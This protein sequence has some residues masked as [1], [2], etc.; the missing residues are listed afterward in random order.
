MYLR[1]FTRQADLVLPDWSKRLQNYY[2][3]LRVDGRNKTLRRRY[4]RAVELEKLRLAELG[5]CQLQ[6]IGVCRYL[7]GFNKGSE[8]RLKQLFD[9]NHKQLHLPFF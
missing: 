5:L 7:S 8:Q 3:V 2:V 9:N 1:G 4:Y 6:I